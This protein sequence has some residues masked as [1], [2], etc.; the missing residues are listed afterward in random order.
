M[1]KMPPDPVTKR[2]TFLGVTAQPVTFY[3]KLPDMFLNG[4]KYESA[5]FKEEYKNWNTV[6]LD[7]VPDVYGFS[8]MNEKKLA[9]MGK[10]K[11]ENSNVTFMGFNLMFHA[12]TNNDSGVIKMMN[13]IFKSDS[14]YLPKRTVVPVSVEYGRNS[15]T[16]TSP[17]DDVNT[18]I[19]YLDAYKSSSKIYTSENLL[20]VENGQ[21]VVNVTY[22]YL[23]QG[24]VV[25]IIGVL[26][27]S[28]LLFFIH[29]NGV[30]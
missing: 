6:Y 26:G 18:T 25:S 1:N 29:R 21:T 27:M 14:S 12:M 7:N 22:P 11:G 4:V 16:I 9:F 3:N 5:D 13:N 28:V 15:I 2:M 17:K 20:N 19:A 24:I 8:W 30:D 23:Y 10:G